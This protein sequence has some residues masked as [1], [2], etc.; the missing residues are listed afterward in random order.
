MNGI[1]LQYNV[2]YTVMFFLFLVN[3]ANLFLWK[4]YKLNFIIDMCVH[5]EN[6][7]FR[8]GCYPEGQVSTGILKGVSLR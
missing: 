1:L 6:S 4:I 7:I 8:F 2:I 5:G 3:S